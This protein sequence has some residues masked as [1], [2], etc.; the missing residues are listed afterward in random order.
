MLYA[1]RACVGHCG[2]GW[3]S[4]AAQGVGVLPDVDPKLISWFGEL[5]LNQA[6]LRPFLS[7]ALEACLNQHWHAVR[8]GTLKQSEKPLAATKTSHSSGLMNRRV[9]Q[10]RQRP[11][12]SVSFLMLQL[13]GRYRSDIWRARLDDFHHLPKLAVQGLS[14]QSMI[15]GNWQQAEIMPVYPS[16]RASI[17][18]GIDSAG[19]TQ[20]RLGRG[21]EM[22]MRACGGLVGVRSFVRSLDGWMPH[23]VADRNQTTRHG[24]GRGGCGKDLVG[25]LLQGGW[26]NDAVALRHSTQCFRRWRRHGTCCRERGPRAETVRA[27]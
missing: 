19:Q 9:L 13:L 10:K 16:R 7:G 17:L 2:T 4:V 27:N 25:S 3:L 15:G 1:G 5:S 8:K 20:L 26:G 12:M 6:H 21:T 18:L 14:G 22:P 24:A 23:A 11:L